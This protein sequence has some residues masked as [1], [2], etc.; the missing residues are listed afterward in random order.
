MQSTTNTMSAP[1][2]L[3]TTVYVETA[4]VWQEATVVNVHATG[5]SRHRILYDI[6]YTL[7][8]MIETHVEPSRVFPVTLFLKEIVDKHVINLVS[9]NGSVT[10]KQGSEKT[11]PPSPQLNTNMPNINAFRTST[12]TQPRYAEMF[13]TMQQDVNMLRQKLDAVLKGPIQ[14][15]QEDMSKK[16]DWETFDTLSNFSPAVSIQ[17]DLESIDS[18]SLNE[19][20]YAATKG[21][22][23]GKRKATRASKRRRRETDI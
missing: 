5:H 3:N 15:Q 23:D 9:S 14:T 17:G 2:K 1:Y 19:F 6:L 11:P 16:F 7:S 10:E 4:D 22:R 20:N 18:I 12:P 13:L 8:N 21:E